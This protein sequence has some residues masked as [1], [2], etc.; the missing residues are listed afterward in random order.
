MMDMIQNQKLSI[1]ILKKIKPQ[2]N[3]W[4]KVNK[5]AL[6]QEYKKEGRI[7]IERLWKQ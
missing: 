7:I 3:K 6:F 1:P 4:Q 5:N 2:A